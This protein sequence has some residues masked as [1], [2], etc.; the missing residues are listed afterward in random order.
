MS[1]LNSGY[2]F[3]LDSVSVKGGMEDDT[4]SEHNDK[5]VVLVLGLSDEVHFLS[6]PNQPF[7]RAG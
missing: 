7:P 3:D 5:P 4:Y 2:V 6:R 1:N